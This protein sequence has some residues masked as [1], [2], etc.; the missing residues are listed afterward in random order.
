MSIRYT[1][2]IEDNYADDPY[3]AV[4]A[5][6]VLGTAGPE[7][8]V[9]QGATAAQAVRDIEWAHVAINATDYED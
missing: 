2:K 6:V 4:A 7:L 9:A 1:I 5:T 8:Y 3:E